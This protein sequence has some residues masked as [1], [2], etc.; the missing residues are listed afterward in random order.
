MSKKNNLSSD[1][2]NIFKSI[3]FQTAKKLICQFQTSI[4]LLLELADS[5]IL[6][7]NLDRFPK[8]MKDAIESF[9]KFN[10]TQQL[11]DNDASIRFVK[12]A[13]S[14]FEKATAD[15]MVKLEDLRLSQ[16]PMELRIAN[17]QM[18]QLERV[19]NMPQ[20]LPGKVQIF[21]EGHKNL[22]CL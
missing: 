11:E 18:M 12:A 1:L 7:Y 10:V 2:G 14:E 16:N 8:A 20:G 15:F 3:L 6:P 9:D 4:H 21:R 5:A 19:F 17:D 22:T 13:V